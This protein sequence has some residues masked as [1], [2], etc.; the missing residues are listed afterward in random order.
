[1][2]F[3]WH[4]FQPETHR[5]SDRGDS[6][7]RRIPGCIREQAPDSCWVTMNRPRKVG[8]THIQ[9]NTL[10]LKLVNEPVDSGDAHPV[11]EVLPG[12]VR[13]PLKALLEVGPEGVR[14]I[15]GR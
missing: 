8:L 13:V 9:G 7:H 3:H 5:S 11:K 6:L 12:K 15:H 2:L 4:E 10:S 14:R 1:M